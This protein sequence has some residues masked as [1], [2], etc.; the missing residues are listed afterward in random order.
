MKIALSH[1]WV[2][3]VLIL[4]AMAFSLVV[5]TIVRAESPS[6]TVCVKK[7]GEMYM[8]GEG[9]KRANCKHNDKLISWNIGGLP[10][11]QGPQGVP[12]VAGP[13]GPQ[14][15]AGPQGPAG[16]D[17]QPGADGAQGPQGVAGPQG[18]QGPAGTATGGGIDKSRTYTNYS[19]V[20][21]ST[22][23]IAFTV[24]AFCNDSN[25]VLLSGGYWKDG[26][27]S[28]QI[29]INW[30]VEGPSG[31]SGWTV[32]AHSVAGGLGL[33]ASANCLRVD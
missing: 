19:S 3:A 22:A 30:A 29:L 17:G 4:G 5:W 11:P 24:E 31:I 13:V 6:I 15:V 12:G 9:F 28:L 27:L 7:E 25:D 33:Q 32:R 20:Q 26:D 8:I 23:F 16:L 2:S 10:G 21:Y 1:K 18:P 14:G